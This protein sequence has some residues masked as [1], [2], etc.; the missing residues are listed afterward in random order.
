MFD[1]TYNSMSVATHGPSTINHINNKLLTLSKS[2]GEYGFGHTYQNETRKINKPDYSLSVADILGASTRPSKHTN[3]NS[4]LLMVDDIDGTR[5]KIS[6]RML[7]TNR[8]VN[9]LNPA[10]SLPA[11]NPADPVVPHFTKD[12][13][14][15]DDIEGTRTRKKNFVQAERLT[16]NVSDIDG[17][18]ASWRPRHQ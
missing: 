8:H 9:P 1:D 18:Q 3:E 13:M 7:H 15:I 14:C 4:K 11:Y 5:A 16:N 2:T 6:N 17:A 10:Y 12:S